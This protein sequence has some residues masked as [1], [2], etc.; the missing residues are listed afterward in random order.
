MTQ[1]Q[2]MFIAGAKLLHHLCI[3]DRNMYKAPFDAELWSHLYDAV[4]DPNDLDLAALEDA[5]NQYF[6]VA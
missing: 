5:K 3:S 6:G 1:K 2:R 4:E